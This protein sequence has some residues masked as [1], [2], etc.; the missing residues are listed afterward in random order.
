MPKPEL[1]TFDAIGTRWWC[2]NLDGGSVPVAAQHAIL[3][4]ADEFNQAFTRFDDSSL[5]GQLN[6]GLAVMNPP[7]ELL[8][9]L[10]FSR[11]LYDVSDG[12]F[13]VSVGGELHRTGYGA[14]GHAAPIWDDPWPAIKYDTRHVSIPATMTIDFGGIGK[15]WLIDSFAD[16]LAR[17]GVRHFIV[18]GGGDM[19]VRSNK[20]INITLEHPLDNSKFVGTTKIKNGALAVSGNGKRQW[21]YAGKTYGHLVDPTGASGEQPAAVYVKAPSATIAD[22]MATI[23]FLQ[24]SLKEKLTAAYDLNVVILEASNIKS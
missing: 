11:Q 16:I 24:P 20:A 10:R 2:E 8:E 19:L 4:R 23:L 6:R 9:L 3:S 1:F 15:G 5:V 14:R 13:N 7:E 12:A 18:N 21:E 17:H 22:A